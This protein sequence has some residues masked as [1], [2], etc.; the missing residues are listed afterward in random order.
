MDENW[1]T[2]RRWRGMVNLMYELRGGEA[3][4]TTTTTTT[5]LG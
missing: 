4:T 2:G 5:L 1:D 3:L